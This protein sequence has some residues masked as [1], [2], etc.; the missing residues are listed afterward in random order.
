MSLKSQYEFCFQSGN[1]RNIYFEVGFNRELCLQ[2]AQ[3][4]FSAD[5]KVLGFFP[6]TAKL[7]HEKSTPIIPK[8]WSD[9]VV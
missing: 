5:C 1:F 4:E 9:E 6:I 3:K 8:P 2:S 7:I